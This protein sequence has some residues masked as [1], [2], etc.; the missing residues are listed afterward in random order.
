M[1]NHFS[2]SIIREM[3]CILISFC[4]SLI[5]ICG[6][7]ASEILALRCITSDGLQVEEVRRVIKKCMKKVTSSDDGDD[8]RGYD[9]Y[10]NF[11][12]VDYEMKDVNNGRG[13]NGGSRDNNNDRMNAN[14]NYNPRFNQYDERSTQT[15]GNYYE[16]NRPRNNR[17]DP[18]VQQ[19]QQFNPYQRPSPYMHGSGNNNYFGSNQQRGDFYN[20]RAHQNKNTNNDNS[21]DKHERDRACILQ[22]FFQELKMVMK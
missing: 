16:M 3:K 8:V 11:E 6:F 10:E 7:F 19:Q 22:C 20:N 2:F 1:K 21:T 5:L 13:G 15:G 14:N 18:W 17:H 12:S 9:E 4:L